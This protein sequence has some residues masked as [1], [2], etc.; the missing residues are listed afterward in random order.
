M[1]GGCDGEPMT[2]DKSV[3]LEYARLLDD[4]DVCGLNEKDVQ[5]CCIL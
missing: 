1:R 4:L 2:S 5:S 3:D